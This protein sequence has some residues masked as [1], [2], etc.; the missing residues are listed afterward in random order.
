[1]KMFGKKKKLE[2]Q[3][4]ELSLQKQQQEQA[5]RWNELQ[6]QE[7]LRAKEEEMRRKEQ[8]WETERLERQRREYE[9]REAERQK[10]KAMEWE[11]QQRK[12]REVVKHERVKKTTPEA[13]RG[14]RDL[15]RQRYQLDMEIWSLKGARKPD[16][17]IVFEKMEKADAVL[18][19]ICA[20][21]ETWE[22]NEAFWTAQEWVLASKIKEQVMKSGKRVWR[23]NPPWNG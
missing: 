15:I 3:L 14:L 6:M 7:Q 19:E 10:Q 2:K 9:L 5:Q 8:I 11:E 21:V 1:M 20:M 4:A 22:E 23:N 17:P 12:D 16:H 18:Q 13:L